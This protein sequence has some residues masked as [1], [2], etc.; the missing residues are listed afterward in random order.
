MVIALIASTI[1]IGAAA[2]ATGDGEQ[3]CTITVVDQPAYDE[4]VPA[5]PSQW[6]NWSPNKD[7]G[8]FD[9]PPAFP[10]DER[11]TWQGPHTEGGPGQDQVGTFQQGNGHG[12]WFHRE[13]GVAEYTI[14]H[15]AVTH[16]EEVP[17]T[18]EPPTEEPPVV[19]PPKVDPPTDKVTDTPVTD[20]PTSKVP[21]AAPEAGLPNTGA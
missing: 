3:P 18:E 21:T 5:V 4:V 11:G 8:P 12:S 20:K 9:G 6:W 7:Q 17:C 2:Q 16:T 13:A 14:H 19:T 10:T 1:G 15:D